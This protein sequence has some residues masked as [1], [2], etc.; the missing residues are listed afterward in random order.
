MDDIDEIIGRDGSAIMTARRIADE[1]NRGSKRVGIK[2]A[3]ALAKGFALRDTQ[4]AEHARENQTLRTA[5][6]K[7]SGPT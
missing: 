3:R 2:A 4:A 5:I 6:A 1:I 7:L